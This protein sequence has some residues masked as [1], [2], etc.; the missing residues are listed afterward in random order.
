MPV[1]AGGSTVAAMSPPAV[2]ASPSAWNDFVLWIVLALVVFALLFVVAVGVPRRRAARRDDDPAAP[3]PAAARAAAP[4]REHASAP[5]FALV[6]FDGLGTAERA[7]GRVHDGTPDASWIPDVAFVEH[8]RHGRLVVRGTFAGRYLDIGDAGGHEAAP[9]GALF[10]ELRAGVAEGSS[11]I[12]VFA[13]TDEVDAMEEAF[14]EAGGRL[15]RHRVSG[16]EAAALEASV[17][18][19]PRAAPGPG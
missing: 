14:G 19:A 17:A 11:A 9:S 6:T 10:D 1:L 5:D 4:A 7:Y 2:L 16:D 15:E 18:D 13:P 8:H 12:V 3:A